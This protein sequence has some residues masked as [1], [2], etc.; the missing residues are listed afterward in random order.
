MSRIAILAGGGRL[1]LMIAESAV[2]RGEA[3]HIVGIEGEADPAIARFPHTWV[4]WGQI[5]R[6][7]A[8]LQ[9]D[10]G[11]QMVIAGAVTRPDLRRIRPDAGFFKSLPQILR[12]LGGGDDSVLT[13]VVRFFE[14]NGMKVLGVHD[15]APELLVGTGSMGGVDLSEADRADAEIGFAVRRALAPVDAGQSVVI[16][17]GR[18]LAIEGAEGTD[19]MLQ[20]VAALRLH[21]AASSSAGVLAKGPK[22]GQELRVDMPAIGPRTI[23]QAAAAGLAGVVAEAGAVLVLDRAET[24]AIADARGCAIHG[25][26]G[27]VRLP[28]RALAAPR[29]RIGRV[30]GRVRPSR[31]DVA[32]IERGLAA[33]ECLAPFATGGGAVVVRHYVRAIEAAEGA[34]AMLERAAGLRRQWGLRW[35][36]V[37]VFVRRVGDA[38]EDG[39]ALKALLAQAAA[40]E[41]AGIAVTGKAQALAPYEDAGPLADDL[42]LFLVLCDAT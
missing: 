8:T 37:G 15:V 26:A 17:R 2:G 41:L 12:L 33:V 34:A 38:T 18:V 27:A 32:D 31:H 6:M 22:P 24:I 39:S 3:V 21:E 40:Q 29:R 30:I 20:R 10:E 7:V 11:R 36:K 5:G 19:A 9:G 4:N 13:R 16:A 25:L 1:P 28:Q 23:E 42:S 14:A 35:R